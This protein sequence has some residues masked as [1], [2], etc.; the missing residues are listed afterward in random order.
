MKRFLLAIIS[1]FTFSTCLNAAHIIGGEMRYVYVGPGVAPNSK[2]YRIVMILLKG[3]DPAGAPLAATYVVGIFNND[4][5]QKVFGTAANNNWLISQDPP[6]TPSVPI[7]FP[8][9]IQNAPVLN[10][11][12]AT[13]TMTVELPNNSN[14]YTV[15][16]QTC[17]RINGLI[18]VANSTGST[19]NCVIPGTNQIPSGNDSSPQ[20]GLPINVI[21]KLAPFIL[22]FSA[23]DPD[24]GDSLV[25][26]LCD[27]YNGGLAVNA[28]FNDP[29]PPPY[30]SANYN[31]PYSGSNPMGTGVVINPQTGIISGTA[32]DLGKY[33]VCVCIN[34]Y[35]NGVLIATHRKDLIVQVS[36]CQ[37]TSA[38][39]MPSFVTCDG[40]NIQFSHTSTG[41]NT[42]FWDFGDPTTLADT[43]NADS[44]SWD[45]TNAGAGTY[46]VKFV[47]NRGTSC[48]DSTTRTIGVFP[49]FFPG[50]TSAGNCYLNPF[51]FT[52]TTRTNYGFVDT[53]SWNFGDATTLADTSHLQNPQWTYAT[54]GP[55]TVTL[56]VSNS[57]GCQNTIQTIINVLDKPVITLGFT[58]TLI[59]LNDAITLN[60]N[61][62]G[63]FSWTPP[64]N[65]IN[66]NTATPTVNPTTDT[67]YYVNLNDNGCQNRDSVHIRVVAAVS[68]LARADTTICLGDPVQLNATGNGLLFQWTPAGTLNNPNIVNPI[69]TPVAASTTYQVTATVGSCSATDDVTIL[70]VPYPVANAGPDQTICY[71]TSTLLSGSHNG[72]SFS[73]SPTSYLSNPA[74]LNPV[75]TPPRTVTYVLTV[76]DN[77]GCPKPGRDTIVVTVNPRVR[78]YAGRDTSVIVGQPLQ[79]FATGG[80]SYSWTPA[81]GLNNPNIQNPVGTYSANIDTIMY[82]VVVRDNIGCADSSYVI[83]R[84]F[85]TAPSIFVPT[86]FTPNGD[87]LND[88]VR[89]ICVGI[90]KINYFNIYNRWGELVFTTTENEKG[91]DGRINGVLQSTNVFVWIVSAEDYLG[92]KYFDKGTVTLIR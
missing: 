87:G 46:T 29:A 36:D 65:I 68:L 91:W 11:T 16:Y 92:G 85:Q 14:G 28:G 8:S 25:Y 2:I 74:I 61:G 89:P 62:T 82:K 63:V 73:W 60:A 51:Q 15:A 32:P 72:N 58:D 71:N 84:V 5:G 20:F 64:I 1:F 37:I 35:R 7:I 34:V 6:G 77:Q 69:A 48:A 47:I 9:C 22:N 19:Y 70:T 31:F 13:Y 21:C 53:W 86:A 66:A 10:Y 67:W 4:N 56:I 80:V 78:A 17:C 33:V 24:P 12:Y 44:P 59:C 57:H 41:A 38:V 27:A 54:P 18:N 43:S 90:R 81:T 39:P 52:D 75:V 23:T 26:S 88:V 83:V 79:L 40:F 49:G 55:K 50:F 45:Y 3:D 30:G 42:V 76:F